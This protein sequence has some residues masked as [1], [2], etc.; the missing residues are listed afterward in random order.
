MLKPL[1]LINCR[2]E[3]KRNEDMFSF[4]RENGFS[5]NFGPILLALSDI[6]ET[7]RDLEGNE[8]RLP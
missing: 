8:V 2:S 7:L 3:P 1:L 5:V 6:F 4:S